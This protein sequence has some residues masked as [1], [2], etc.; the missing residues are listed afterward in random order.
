MGFFSQDDP[1][2]GAEAALRRHEEAL[3]LDPNSVL[4][5]WMSA[6][7]LGDLGRMEEALRRAA[8]AV[9]LAQRSPILLG[10]HGRLLAQTGRRD[11]AR[12]LREELATRARSEFVGPVYELFFSPLL[13]DEA[14]I[15]A[16]LGRN[17]EA[18]TGPTSL[19]PTGIDRELTPLLGHPRLG[20]LVRRLS[21][22]AER[23]GLDPLPT[24][25]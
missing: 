4:N 12:A 15:A 2:A 14:A 18:G 16:A 17:I 11:E 5:L 9:E 25:P 8:R 10:I 21:L 6:V 7:R 1:D 24:S 23:P 13:D 3:S 20:P 22:Y 19:A